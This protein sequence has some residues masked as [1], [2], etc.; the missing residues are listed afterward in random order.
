VATITSRSRRVA[1]VVGCG[2]TTAASVADA[3][4]DPQS[5]TLELVSRQIVALVLGVV[6]V[7]L[8]LGASA[9]GWLGGVVVCGADRAPGCVAWPAPAAGVV[10]VVFLVGVAALL[11]WQLRYLDR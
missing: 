1:A 11:V 6:V 5:Y 8:A 4:T 10:W 7:A 9:V 3:T 2:R